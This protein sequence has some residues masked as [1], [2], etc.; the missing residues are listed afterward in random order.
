M[1][2][3]ERTGLPLQVVGVIEPWAVG[4]ESELRIFLLA[5]GRRL[6]DPVHPDARGSF[7]L[8]VD[9]YKDDRPPKEV[10][11]IA[12]LA[13]RIVG[14]VILTIRERHGG[15]A[16]KL[17]IIPLPSR[18]PPSRADIRNEVVARPSIWALARAVARLHGTTVWRARA[19]RKVMR[20]I[21]ELNR[22]GRLAAASLAGD[23]DAAKAL[24]SVFEGQALYSPGGAPNAPSALLDGFAAIVQSGAYGLPSR[25]CG[26]GMTRAL[27]I[28][29]AGL[30]A[31]MLARNKDAFF[32]HQAAA[33]VSERTRTVREYGASVQR[34]LAYGGAG[35]PPGLGEG[36]GA[37]EPI[38]DPEG[39]MSPGRGGEG[40][41]APD[42]IDGPPEGGDVIGPDFCQL[43]AQLCV[44]LYANASGAAAGDPYIDII[45]S[46]TFIDNAGVERPAIFCSTDFDPNRV[47]VA[48]PAANHAPP[49]FPAPLPANVQLWFRDQAIVPIAVAPDAIQFRISPDPL[50]FLTGF[51]YL[52]TLGPSLQRTTQQLARVCGKFNPAIPD[53][54]LFDR[55]PA[56]QITV[57]YPPL[58]DVFAASQT[59]AEACKNVEL[60]WQ[61]HL[62]HQEASWPI[63]AG[64]NI[65][66]AIVDDQGNVIVP[67][68]GPSGSIQVATPDSR[69]YTLTATSLVGQHA[70]G[71][72]S[73][74]LR[75][76]RTRYVYLEW[77]PNDLQ[78]LTTAP[79]PDGAPIAAGSNGQFNVVVSCNVA[80][81]LQLQLASDSQPTLQVPQQAVIHQGEHRS[82]QP[83]AFATAVRACRPVTVTVAAPGHT[84]AQP[85]GAW[86]PPGYPSGDP[87]PGHY[88]V[89]APP[90]IAW[91]GAAPNPIEG[92]AVSADITTLCVPADA[93]RLEWL[94]TTPNGNTQPVLAPDRVVNVA[95]GL[96]HLT[97][98]AGVLTRG[99]WSLQ[100]RIASRNSVVSNQLQLVVAAAPSFTIDVRDTRASVEWGEAATFDVVVTGQNIPG[101]GLAVDLEAI[102]LPAGST[103]EFRDP[104][105]AN[106]VSRRVTLTQAAPVQH[107]TLSVA[108]V[109]AVT[110]LGAQAFRV[111]GTAALATGPL[112]VQSPTR[113]MTIR[114][115]HGDFI[116]VPPLQSVVPIGNP[117]TGTVNA[118]CDVNTPHCASAGVAAVV[119]GTPNNYMT[120]FETP[121]GNSMPE[122]A[123]DDLSTGLFAFSHGCRVGLA[124]PRLGHNLETKF[125]NLGFPLTVFP[126]GHAIRIGGL[127]E[128]AQ[129]RWQGYLFSRDETLVIIWGSSG[130]SMPPPGGG[131]GLAQQVWLWDL[132]GQRELITT[133]NLYTGFYPTATL[134]APNPPHQPDT[135]VVFTYTDIAGQNPLHITWVVPN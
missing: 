2:E 39:G 27:T 84:A 96:Y 22:A 11:V 23:Q 51:V 124:I 81:D 37:T 55:S 20:A 18:H 92:E 126:S 28:I 118:V 134:V 119:T 104:Q 64:A 21:A 16:T 71:S 112:V 103:S 38:L 63:P 4:L 1:N 48:R 93:S 34:A 101:A 30:Q 47:Y 46:V 5:E 26:A 99:A 31:D 44:D 129:D 91:G 52:K 85:P 36:D 82:A 111:R 12:S 116:A 69:T 110:Q 133:N 67:A 10:E 19:P 76:N 88:D 114:R 60:R 17:R 122:P 94:L 8:N 74:T 97:I 66:V 98:V 70:C 125:Y 29:D 41:F 35:G 108:A 75:I 86:P 117:P 95:P 13:N 106:A 131:P 107:A 115:L 57:I 79:D 14:R 78:H 59:D 132:V 105:N 33:F 45:G 123:P 73:A 40:D 9:A 87:E 15:I 32:V 83:I 62:F 25:G 42:G 3:N 120:H 127:F 65:E 102:S 7:V 77:D 49:T 121:N 130:M 6:T 61:A 56:A 54:V 68:G 100:A 72:A 43:V 24:A 128:D 135:T 90:Q 109:F 50:R 80:A 89:F 53:A 58:V 113:N